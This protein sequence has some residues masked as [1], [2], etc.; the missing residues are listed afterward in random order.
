MPAHVVFVCLGNICR[1]PMAQAIF[2][3]MVRK[4]GLSDRISIDSCGTAGWHTGDAPHPGT[5]K[6][7]RAH[8]IPFQHTARQINSGDF[9]SASYLVAM[10]RENLGDMRQMG[11]TQG[12]L[13]L[14]L[15]F[16][17]Q[18]GILD[19]PDPYY[20]NRFEETYRLIEAGC[21]GLLDHIRAQ[22]GL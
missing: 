15:D 14:L 3:E 11:K 21:T 1:S 7:L 13:S 2:A 22:E 19:V 5:Q 12:E 6:V 18:L 17:P 9:L 8:G 4:A 20:T 10:D 16:A